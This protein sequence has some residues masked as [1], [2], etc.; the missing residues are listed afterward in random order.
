L[1]YDTIIDKAKNAPL[2]QTF[3]S[4]NPM[5]MKNYN[6]NLNFNSPVPLYFQL[7]QEIKRLLLEGKIKPGEKLPTE[8]ELSELLGISRGTVNRTMQSLANAGILIRERSIGTF[9]SDN[10]QNIANIKCGDV[11]SISRCIEAMGMRSSAKNIDVSV[12]K[13][14][15]IIQS[16]LEIKPESTLMNI[17]RVYF[18]NDAP[19]ALNIYYLA[20]ECQVE[21][22]PTKLGSGSFYE[23]IL[24]H[25]RIN[26]AS[27]QRMVS[28]IKADEQSVDSL[29]IKIGDPV[30]F[31]FGLDRDENGS[32]IGAY[33][34]FFR[35]DV[36]IQVFIQSNNP[37]WWISFEKLE[38]LI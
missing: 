36:N 4:D 18:A 34:T 12:V 35:V 3:L 7:E 6:V 19:I 21:I 9:I 13:P 14:P 32:R 23:Y 30:L 11:F 33:N 15:K 16:K 2:S 5:I 25:N 38:D 37:T 8:V 28:A 26:I 1:D 27:G 31:L 24:K 29:N 20:P 17:K 10:G 22:D